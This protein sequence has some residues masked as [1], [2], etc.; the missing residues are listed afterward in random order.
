MGSSTFIIVCSG[1][2]QTVLSDVSGLYHVLLQKYN[3]S[4]KDA[5]EL[6]DFLLPMLSKFAMD[7]ISIADLKYR[8]GP[9]QTSNS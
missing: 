6:T 8:Y 5:T 2:D 1:H 7:L 4:R 3:L 9:E